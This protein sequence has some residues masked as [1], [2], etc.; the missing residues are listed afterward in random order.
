MLLLT[1]VLL[2]AAVPD[3]SLGQEDE[4]EEEEEEEEGTPEF[5]ITPEVQKEIL[6]KHNKIRRNV[7]P[8]AANM[9]KMVWNEKSA[10]SAMKWASECQ[11]TISPAENRTFKGIMCSENIF[12][13]NILTTWTKAIDVWEKRKAFF[14][15]GVGAIDPGKLIS[16]Y[17]Q[18]IWYNSYQVGCGISLCPGPEHAFFFYVCQYCPPANREDFIAKPYKSGPPC[19]DCPKACEDGLCTNPCRHRNRGS[20]C[21]VLKNLYTCKSKSIKRSCRATCR[22]KTEII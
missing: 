18:L 8:T 2:L 7:K 21:T 10:E 15:Y 9:L 3:Q 13:T 1:I 17:T 6:D 19:A 5:S 4:E 11:L 20:N 16:S 12:Y 14:Q 22:C